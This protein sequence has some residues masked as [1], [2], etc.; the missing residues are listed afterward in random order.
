MKKITFLLFLAYLTT[1]SE[2][3]DI[4]E[5]KITNTENIITPGQT[6]FYDFVIEGNYGYDEIELSVY[7]K[8]INTTNRIAYSRWNREGDNYLNFLTPTTKHWYTATN[9]NYSEN[10]ELSNPIFLLPAILE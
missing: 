7:Y 10:I 1:Y 4:K 5:F 2:T 9:F 6:I 3:L 8:E